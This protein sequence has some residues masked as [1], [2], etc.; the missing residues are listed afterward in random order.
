MTAVGMQFPTQMCGNERSCAVTGMGMQY[1]EWHILINEGG[2]SVSGTG[3]QYTARF[4]R[5][6]HENWPLLWMCRTGYC[7]PAPV[8]AETFPAEGSDKNK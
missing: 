8:A 1:R 2:Y 6:L 3:V 4:S 7:T 5:W